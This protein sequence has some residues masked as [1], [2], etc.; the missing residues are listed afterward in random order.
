MRFLMEEV[1]ARKE[2]ERIDEAKR[3]ES[4]KYGIFEEP[5]A[6]PLGKRKK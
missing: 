3:A 5:K 6:K 2:Q 4:A 1:A